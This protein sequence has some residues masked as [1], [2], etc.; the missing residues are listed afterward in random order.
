[1]PKQDQGQT[2]WW[3]SLQVQQAQWYAL[4]QIEKKNKTYQSGVQRQSSQELGPESTEASCAEERHTGPQD[5]ERLEMDTGRGCGHCAAVSFLIMA[6][7]F[8]CWPGAIMRQRPWLG[9]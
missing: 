3:L 7:Y 4:A 2:L 9:G 5:A 6:T 8:S 1:M